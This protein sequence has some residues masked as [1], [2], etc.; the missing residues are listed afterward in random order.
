MDSHVH[1]PI[2]S[3]L[4]MRLIEAKIMKLELS[5]YEYTKHCEYN[6]LWTKLNTEK[7]ITL[8]AQTPIAANYLHRKARVILSSLLVCYLP[9]FIILSSMFVW[10]S[11]CMYV[12]ISLPVSLSLS[13]FWFVDVLVCWSFGLSTFWFVDVSARRRFGLPTF[14]SVDVWVCRR[15]GLRRLGCQ[16]FGLSTF[17]PVIIATNLRNYE[18]NM[19]YSSIDIKER[20]YCKSNI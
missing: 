18:N 13:T 3:A 2:R 14:R 15:L 19:I 12:C 9:T 6:S 11:V 7:N 17:W 10:W 1:F 5:W 4:T 20:T 16:R 8:R